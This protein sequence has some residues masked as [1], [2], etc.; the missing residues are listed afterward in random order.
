VTVTIPEDFLSIPMDAVLIGQ[1]LTNLLENAVIHARG[2]TVLELLVTLE[3]RRVRFTVRDNGCGIA[4][5]RLED[6]FTGY[7]GSSDRQGDAQRRNM[8]IGLSVC[9]TI[10]KAH[11]GR[12][13]AKN[14]PTGG[15]EFTFTLDLEE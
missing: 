4:P 10:V 13:T 1:V 9:A 12:I 6:L 2:M 7:L 8:G 3:D 15:A 14:R 11:G 5:D